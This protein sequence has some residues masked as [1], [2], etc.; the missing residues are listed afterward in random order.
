MESKLVFN[1]DNNI[2]EL[3][4]KTNIF[5]PE[6]ILVIENNRYIGYINKYSEDQLHMIKSR[7]IAGWTYRELNLYA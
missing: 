1:V 4:E 2:I 5:S 3:Q 6:V 7:L